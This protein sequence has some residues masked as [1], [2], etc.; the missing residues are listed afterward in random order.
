M[1]VCVC[2]TERENSK[3]PS[4][5]GHKETVYLN[6]LKHDHKC[7]FDSLSLTT[8]FMLNLYMSPYYYVY[9]IILVVSFFLFN[10][11]VLVSTHLQALYWELL[12]VPWIDVHVGTLLVSV[13]TLTQFKWRCW[14]RKREKERERGKKERNRNW[15]GGNTY[16]LTPKQ[17]TVELK[18]V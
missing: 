10:H 1:C 11:S 2:V 4:V 12:C 17:K 3:T 14:G 8:I 7:Y 5:S 16:L 15:T 18:K 6:L 9:K 13:Q